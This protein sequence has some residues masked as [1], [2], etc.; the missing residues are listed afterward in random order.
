MSRHIQLA[1]ILGLALCAVSASFAVERGEDRFTVT[2][3]FKAE[4]PVEIAADSFSASSNGWVVADGNVLI[5]HTDSQLT[6]DHI[7][8]NKNTGEIVAEGNVVLVREG[9]GV[10]R[11]DRMTYNYK[12]GEG[13]T[14]RLDVQSA[15]FRVIAEK[16]KRLGDGSYELEDVKVTTCTNDEFSLHYYVKAR[17]AY[18][19]PE[20]YVVLKNATFI[21]EDMPFLY[22][23]SAKKSLVDHFGWRF[24]PGYETDWGGYLLTT[25]KRQI[26]DYGG[27]HYDS[28]NSFSHIDY[29]TERGFAL[30]EDVGWHFGDNEIGDG[31]YGMVGFYGI[32]DDNPMDED[33]DREKGTDIPEDFRYRAFID[34]SSALSD[35][36]SLMIRSSYFSD[37]YVFP[38]FYED[39]YKRLTTP[40]S[41]AAYTHM[42][43]GWSAG[44]GVYHRANEFYESV[45]RM[46]DAW[47]DILNR[48][49]GDTPFYYESQTQGGFLQKEFP[50][51][52]VST[53]KPKDSYDSF[54]FDTRHALYLPKKAF[55][56]LSLVPRAVYRGTYYGT[57]RERRTV[58]KTVG[59]NT[60]TSTQYVDGDADFRNLYELGLETSF[61][62]Y[63]IFEDEAGR[64]RHIVE[65]YANY[66]L[67]PEPNIRP[68]DLYRFDDI[69]G[70]D[71]ANNIRFGLRQYLQ[72]KVEENTVNRIYA[73]IYAIYDIEDAKDESGL[74][75]VGFDGE[76]RP[77]DSIYLD[78]DTVYNVRESELDY[79][80]IWLTLW[81]GDTFEIAGELYIKE[82]DEEPCAQ[83]AGAIQVN[84]TEHWG[85][86]VYVRYD[87]ELARL[88][89]ISGHI[90]YNLDCISFRLH[91]R[92]EPAFTRDDGTER[93]AK[94][95]VS[96]YTWLRAF[97]EKRYE[98]KMR[99]D[100]D[101]MD[102]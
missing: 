64:L 39:E 53:N 87:S 91:G 36:D 14:P 35:A 21:F 77:T 13:V 51:Y 63:G 84:F 67:V 54:R 102:D 86:K 50:D 81:Q 58:E 43:D 62:A 73:D 89:Q 28:V 5:R 55:G 72:R 60:V 95:R 75:R 88:E 101:Y 82:D 29:R 37:S 34:M 66:T 10:T 61:K 8:I 1:S 12:T 44:L 79:S 45:N 3:P 40:D 33:Y 20:Q 2:A 57:T 83:Y 17:Q 18:Y 78:V 93:E 9:Q 11:T 59:T 15:V 92:Y 76:F 22:L 98:R 25:Y 74:R 6:A 56:F 70:L 27:E 80:D 19:L 4:V 46:P 85:A 41:F 71:K 31:H 16:A 97:P 90:Q 68:T 94:I 23:S 65:P 7:R 96:F 99:E 48:Q 49:I 42:G 38:D 47:L 30:G 24:E 52:G 26:A 100:I 32:F 69:D